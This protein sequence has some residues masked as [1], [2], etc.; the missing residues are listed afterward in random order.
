MISVADTGI[1]IPSELVPKIFD[2]F[3]QVHPEVRERA[4]RTWHRPGARATTVEMHGGTV[5]ANSE[6]PATAPSSS[7]GCRSVGV[8]STVVSTA[9]RA[10]RS[11]RRDVSPRRI[12]VAD[13]NSDAAEAL[14][15]QLQLAGHDVRTAHDG[16]EA[17]EV[18]ETFAPQ[19]VLLDLG[20][21][22]DGRVR[23]GPA[24]SA[25]LVGQERHAHRADRMG[26]GSRIASGR[27]RPASMRIS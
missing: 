23:D 6:G 27:R 15:L 22:Q 3:T 9:D 5:T 7:S 12:L 21:P 11:G 17:L 2:L 1:G 4:G 25:A 18:A 14:A 10:N 8:Q 20:M 26:A 24:D 19:V 16:V 13:D